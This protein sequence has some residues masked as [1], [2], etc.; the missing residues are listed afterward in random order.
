MPYLDESVVHR[1]AGSS[2]HDSEVHEKL[3][4]P[5]TIAETMRTERLYGM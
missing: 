3:Y 2:I 4:S 5:I 1:G